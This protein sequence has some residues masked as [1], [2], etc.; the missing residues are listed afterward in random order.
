MLSVSTSKINV[1]ISF[2]GVPG[3]ELR[4]VAMETRLLNGDGPAVGG[5]GGHDLW[6]KAATIAVP[7]A[8]GCI[9]VL[10]V[11]LAIRML[12]RDRENNNDLASTY[13]L[14]SNRNDFQIRSVWGKTRQIQHQPAYHH[15]PHGQQ[16]WKDRQP[17][18]QQQQQHGHR[19]PHVPHQMAPLLHAPH[20]IVY[21]PTV[22]KIIPPKRMWNKNC[23]L[24]KNP[25]VLHHV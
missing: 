17:M 15:V 23:I 13:T 19:H 10:L 2:C 8:G 3:V 25:S 5:S 21:M 11:L 7:I 4:T 20:N 6:L 22:Q 14:P 18:I 1:I 12:R 16:Q 9:L 24:A